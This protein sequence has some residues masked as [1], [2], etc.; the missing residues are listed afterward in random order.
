MLCI[1]Q[2]FAARILVPPR[3]T[4]LRH[5]RKLDPG[6]SLYTSRERLAPSRRRRCC[7]E[8]PKRGTVI[9]SFQVAVKSTRSAAGKSLGS[10]GHLMCRSWWSKRTAAVYVEPVSGRSRPGL[11][12]RYVPE[13][14]PIPNLLC[15]RKLE[16]NQ[17]SIYHRARTC[18]RRFCGK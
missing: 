18:M 9:A 7:T 1:C 5:A 15:S 3:R 10:Y 11:S 12:T 13:T 16:S 4:E 14:V 6:S 17:S 2:S 8:Q